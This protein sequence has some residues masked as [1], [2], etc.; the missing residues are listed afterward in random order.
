MESVERVKSVDRVESEESMESPLEGA[1]PNPSRLSD[2]TGGLQEHAA[3][4]FRGQPCT[5]TGWGCSTGLAWGCSTGLGVQHSTQLGVQHRAGMG[6]QHSTQ[7]GVQ[8]STQLGVQHRA[9]P[10]SSLCAQPWPY[11]QC[12]AMALSL[13]PSQPH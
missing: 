12:T 10:S 6:V 5:S 13:T 1:K 3:L 8:H 4:V 11:P 9:V 7:L 2:A